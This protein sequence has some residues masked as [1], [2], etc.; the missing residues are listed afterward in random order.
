MSFTSSTA[1]M[2]FMTFMS[3]VS[4]TRSVSNLPERPGLSW[5]LAATAHNRQGGQES[6]RLP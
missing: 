4:S 2:T 6:T 5:R 3:S 1:F